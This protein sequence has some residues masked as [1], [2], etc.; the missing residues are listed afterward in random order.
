MGDRKTSS[1]SHSLVRT[2]LQHVPLD[3]DLEHTRQIILKGKGITIIPPNIGTLL[4]QVRR[5]DLSDNDLCDISP[6]ASLQKLTSLNLTRNSRLD[7]LAPLTSLSLTVCTV[8]H[9][10][11]RSL[12]GIEGCA[13]T[14]KTL[15]VN[16][17]DLIIQA[18]NGRYDGNLSEECVDIAVKNYTVLS[19]LQ[20]CETLVLSRNPFLCKL[21]VDAA[22]EGDQEKVETRTTLCTEN[23][24]RREVDWLH[25]LSFL[26]KMKSLRKLSL[27]GCGL[28]SLPS[29]LFLLKVTELRLSQNKL[30]SLIPES[31][32]LQSVKILDVSHNMLESMSTLR[33]CRFVK[34]LSIAGNTFMKINETS[35][36]NDDGRKS[37]A[38]GGAVEVSSKQLENAVSYLTKKMPNL[39]SVDGTP[40]KVLK[41]RISDRVK[42]R[43][44]RKLEDTG[45]V[46]KEE[47]NGGGSVPEEEEE[48]IVVQPP[49]TVEDTVRVPIVRRERANMFAHY[50]KKIV[51]DGAAVARLLTRRRVESFTW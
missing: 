39:E 47:Q 45:E 16:D 1:T 42:E 33:R 36:L 29:G 4:Q 25:P 6:I 37:T 41:A 22:V 26:A 50:K 32:L 2:F 12:V 30:R 46:G 13:A 7:S 49:A 19:A 18:P 20:A 31:I 3:I 11:L 27:S 15:V 14:L 34:H 43:N 38:E 48:D 9:C 5:L 10:S 23:A 8:A 35:Q 17:N 28:T 24:P 21:H 51:A 40:L 44:K